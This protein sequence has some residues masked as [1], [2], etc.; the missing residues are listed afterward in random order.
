MSSAP[1][2]SFKVAQDATGSECALFAGTDYRIKGLTYNKASPGLSGGIAVS[3]A[4]HH[5]DRILA[6]TVYR[7]S[8]TWRLAFCSVS[9]GSSNLILSFA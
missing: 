8:A 1:T 9:T 2:E 7:E 6:D 4:C 5:R 3:D